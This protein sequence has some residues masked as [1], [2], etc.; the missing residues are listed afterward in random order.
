MSTEIREQG[1]VQELL[2]N[3]AFLR[4]ARSFEIYQ[5]IWQDAGENRNIVTDRMA[6][7]YDAS[8]EMP[9]DERLCVLQEQWNKVWNSAM[10]LAEEGKFTAIKFAE[11]ISKYPEV[12]RELSIQWGNNR[13]AVERQSHAFMVNELLSFKEVA[14]GNDK[15][16]DLQIRAISIEGTGEVVSLLLD[17][18]KKLAYMIKSGDLGDVKEISMVSWMLGGPFNDKAKMLFG[19]DVQINQL[20]TYAGRVGGAEQVPLRF[21][22]SSLE[23]YL[24]T[25]K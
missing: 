7:I 22:G 2:S 19:N 6:E 14:R 8:D 23:T 21:N 1:I 17:G 3:K 12:A 11:E 15:I 18:L 20:K 9:Q 24:K 25:G 10:S 5:R 16:L 4:Q 13:E